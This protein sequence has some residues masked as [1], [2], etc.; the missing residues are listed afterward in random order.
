MPKPVFCPGCRSHDTFERKPD[1]DILM[2][3]KVFEK[4]WVCK[5]CGYKAIYPVKVERVL[6]S[7][8]KGGHKQ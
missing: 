5:V 4:A 3:D 2:G 7:T 1:K 6:I 8:Q